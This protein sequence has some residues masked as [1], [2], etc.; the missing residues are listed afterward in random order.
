MD[1]PQVI[2]T[3]I[4]TAARPRGFAS[5]IDTECER[6]SLRSR[7]RMARLCFQAGKRCGPFGRLED[8]MEQAIFVTGWDD[9]DITVNKET[10]MFDITFLLSGQ[11]GSHW[12]G[13]VLHFVGNTY[14][15]AVMHC[16]IFQEADS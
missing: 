6:G 12:M 14:H 2:L 13:G 9:N 10:G 7:Y 1:G 4:E 8:G 11:P 5:P 16:Y 3:K 15:R